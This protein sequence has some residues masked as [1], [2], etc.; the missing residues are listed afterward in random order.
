MLAKRLAVN[1]LTPG[2]PAHALFDLFVAAQTCKEVQLKFAELCRHLEVDSQDYRN[3]Y[4]KLKERLNYWKAKDLWQK[5]DSR[6]NH[7]DY[8]QGKPSFKHNFFNKMCSADVRVINCMAVSVSV[9]GFK[10]KELRGKLAIGI[11]ANFVNRH[12]AAEAQVPEISGVARIYNQ[13]FFQELHT[14]KGID[15]ENIVYYKDDTHYFVMTAKKNSLLKKGVIKQDFSDADQLLAPANVNQEALLQYARDAAQFSTGGKLPDMEFALNHA[16]QQD[17]A[18]FDFTCMHRAENASLVRERRGKKLLIGLV[19]DCLVEPFWPLGTGIARGFLAAFDT[20]WMVRNW[21]KGMPHLQVLSERESVY[22]L[23]SQT[24]PENTSKNYNAYS[25]DPSTRYPNVNVS[26]IKPKQV[27]AETPQYSLASRKQD[28]LTRLSDLLSWCQKHTAWCNRVQVK[29]LSQSWKSGLALCALIHHFR[30]KLIDMSRLK[31]KDAKF[32]N[33]LA[34]DIL[35]REFGIEPIMSASDMATSKEIDQLSMV[36][37]LT[38]VHNAFTETPVHK[39]LSL[40]RT[41]SAVFF[42]N[43][44]KHNSLQRRKVGA[45]TCDLSPADVLHIAD[46][47]IY[48]L[49]I[50]DNIQ[51]NKNEQHGDDHKK[52]KEEE[53]S[54][55]SRANESPQS[56]RSVKRKSSYKISIDPHCDESTESDILEKQEEEDQLANRAAKD[57]DKPGIPTDLSTELPCPGAVPAPVPSPRK[58]RTPSAHSPV[59]KPRTIH[60]VVPSPNHMPTT[61]E[62]IAS[63]PRPKLSLKKLQLTDEEKTQLV[64]LSFS[65]D[66][67]SETPASS[68]AA[69]TSSSNKP[70]DGGEEEGYWSGG[71]SSLSHVREKKNRRC[72][73]RKGEPQKP[74]QIQQGRLRSKFSPWNLSSP[75]LQQRFSVLRPAGRR[76]DE[77]EEEEEE[78]DNEEALMTADHYLDGQQEMTKLR[79]LERRAKMSE[80]QRFHKAQSIQR[81]LEEIEV[82]FKELEEKGVVLERSLRGEP[83]SDGSVTMIDDWIELVQQKND[84]VSE[85]SDL[86]VASRQLELEDKQSMLELELRRFMEIDDSE[87]TEAQQKEEEQILQQML[88]VVDMRNS[89]VAFLEEKR[90]KELNEE[91]MGS[92]LLET[93]RHSTASAQVHWA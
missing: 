38:Q 32:N 88:E 89:L 75:R 3:F 12:T 53:H 73:R 34:F 31:E 13:K 55:E 92:S 69:S 57:S 39:S 17:V 93:K 52:G 81:R 76:N 68:S 7:S 35:Q 33:Q 46:C 28:S 77:E 60:N 36:L 22:Q 62:T 20:A 30:P 25:I 63:D 24:T 48:Y 9:S 26:S 40:S 45:G 72:F 29:D 66:S 71:A 86:M 51:P 8:E 91:T 5:I 78:E 74:A 4:N 18:M 21:G 83:G 23:L 10:R 82:T 42:L 11:T 61:V 65:Q 67:D 14:E 80:L 59:P 37:Y 90:L 85:E 47:Y 87:K 15:L 70:N 64:N 19:G 6:A 43:K 44:L 58:S 56:F 79:T 1:P 16:G 84:L 54:E 41:R 50:Q 27:G 49:F 2:N